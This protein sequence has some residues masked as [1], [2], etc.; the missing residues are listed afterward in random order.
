MG[1]LFTPPKTVNLQL[2]G[3]D[4]NAFALMGAFSK[5]A[6]REN[7]LKADIDKV[8]DKCYDGDYDNLVATLAD[9]CVENEEDTGDQDRMDDYMLNEYQNHDTE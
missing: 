7:W 9:H 6:R 1:N 4:G 5:Q 2:V 3:L 8:L